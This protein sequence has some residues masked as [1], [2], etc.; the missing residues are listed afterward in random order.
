[1]IDIYRKTIRVQLDRGKINE[2]IS[3]VC[4]L[5]IN[6]GLVHH[7]FSQLCYIR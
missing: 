7:G 4:K 6:R 3:L 5:T 2:T 1:M